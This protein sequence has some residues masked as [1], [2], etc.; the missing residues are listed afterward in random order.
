[1]HNLEVLKAATY[2][3]ALTL[4][5]PK[6][7]LV[8]PGYLA[9]PVVLDG[10]SAEKTAISN[11]PLVVR[12]ERAWRARVGNPRAKPFGLIRRA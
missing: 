3:S 2:N 8:H 10:N 12:R 6:F 5:Q 11:L 4:R 9:D 7:G 1:M